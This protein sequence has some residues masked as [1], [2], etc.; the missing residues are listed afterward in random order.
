[1]KKK[2]TKCTKISNRSIFDNVFLSLSLVLSST[3]SW[4]QID[5]IFSEWLFSFS[6]FLFL[7]LFLYVWLRTVSLFSAITRFAH[8]RNCF[9]Y[10]YRF[11][12][13]R[14]LHSMCFHLHRTL[15]ND[16]NCWNSHFFFIFTIIFFHFWSVLSMRINPFVWFFFSFTAISVITHISQEHQTIKTANA[17][18]KQIDKTLNSD[19]KKQMIAWF[20]KSYEQYLYSLQRINKT[21]VFDCENAIRKNNQRKTSIVL[22]KLFTSIHRWH[23]MMFLINGFRM[24]KIC[25]FYSISRF[26]HNGYYF[27]RFINSIKTLSFSSISHISTLLFNRSYLEKK[28]KCSNQWRWIF[29]HWNFR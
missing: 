18:F 22:L 19:K 9:L 14:N 13:K 16:W 3:N 11:D 24:K 12:F 29:L 2:S 5:R 28:V 8:S 26:I 15:Q 21:V 27:H 17:Y 20:D 10:S 6:F 25:T 1:M 7:S 4:S 23:S